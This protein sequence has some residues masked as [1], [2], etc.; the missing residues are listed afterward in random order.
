MIQHDQKKKITVSEPEKELKPN[1]LE[2]I[3]G[4]RLVS[5]QI[6]KNEEKDR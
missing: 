4:G 3:S 6:P 5:L 1:E 2:K